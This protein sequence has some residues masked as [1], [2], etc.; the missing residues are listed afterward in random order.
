MQ[1]EELNVKNVIYVAMPTAY[2][3]FKEIE[4]SKRKIENI[5]I[6]LFD[7]EF[8]V[9]YPSEIEHVSYQVC[10]ENKRFEKR[11]PREMAENIMDLASATTFVYFNEVIYDLDDLKLY[12]HA[13]ESF[14]MNIVRL[15]IRCIMS[16]LDSSSYQR[17][18][19]DNRGDGPC[20]TL[21]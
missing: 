21:D 19:S 7:E 9:I 16:Q 10:D 14:R 5:L 18:I 6:S 3:T 20:T 1:K 12:L 17:L 2:R 8:E 13:A 15:P 11:T 4:E